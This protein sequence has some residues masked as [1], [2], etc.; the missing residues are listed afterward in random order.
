MDP[1]GTCES[2]QWRTARGPGVVERESSP[3]C[4]ALCFLVTMVWKTTSDGVCAKKGMKE[5]RHEKSSKQI[6]RIFAARKRNEKRTRVAF[7]RLCLPPNYPSHSHRTIVAERAV[8]R[9]IHSTH[10]AVGIS[11]AA[12]HRPTFLDGATSTHMTCM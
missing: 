10:M 11:V 7:I 12:E 5:A 6:A 1:S 8:K 9:F 2:T 4:V 3:P